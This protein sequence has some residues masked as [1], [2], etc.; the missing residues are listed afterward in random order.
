MI[1]N[2]FTII[3]SIIL[4]SSILFTLWS[5]FNRVQYREGISTGSDFNSLFLLSG[6]ERVVTTFIKRSDQSNNKESQNPQFKQFSDHRNS[7]TVGQKE[8]R[9]SVNTSNPTIIHSRQ[10]PLQLINFP[11]R[12]RLQTQRNDCAISRKTIAA[13]NRKTRTRQTKIDRAS[14][15]KLA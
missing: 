5:T 14:T 13:I 10:S 15:A 11:S 3:L 7:K 2:Y 9:L 1:S 4:T 8:S 6:F 12:S